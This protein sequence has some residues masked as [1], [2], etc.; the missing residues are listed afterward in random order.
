MAVLGGVRL[1]AT[2][3]PSAGLASVRA[4][5]RQAGR[6][7]A[8]RATTDPTRQAAR[9][10]PIGVVIAAI[11]ILTMLGMVYLSQ[12]LG[13]GA[14]TRQLAAIDAQAEA[15]GQ[16]QRQVEVRI[17]QQA[18]TNEIAKAARALKLKKMIA[19]PKVLPRPRDLQT[20]AHR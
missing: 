1:R 20:P 19:E 10:R 7:A 6:V 18:E 9:V 15:I 11:L 8:S 12:T 5:P 14:A 2:A 16:Q 17:R 3:T 13:A 4:R